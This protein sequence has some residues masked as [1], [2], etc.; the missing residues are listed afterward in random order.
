VVKPGTSYFHL[1]VAQARQ[2]VFAGLKE[3]SHMQAFR[4]SIMNVIPPF[5]I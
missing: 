5:K 4:A 2:A 3:T 1:D